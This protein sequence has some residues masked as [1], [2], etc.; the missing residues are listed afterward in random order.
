MGFPPK[1]KIL[2][3]GIVCL[4]GLVLLVT[5]AVTSLYNEMVIVGGIPLSHWWCLRWNGIL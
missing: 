2:I 1:T 5:G 3:G 4:I